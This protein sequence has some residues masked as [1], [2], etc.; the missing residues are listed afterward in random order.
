MNTS[1]TSRTESHKKLLKD[2]LASFAAFKESLQSKLS[3]KLA[4]LQT[5][6][7]ERE[8][9]AGETRRVEIEQADALHAALMAELQATHAKEVADLKEKFINELG[10]RVD[11]EAEKRT[12][13]VSGERGETPLLGATTRNT[14]KQQTAGP[15]APLQTMLPELDIQQDLQLIFPEENTRAF[16]R[17]QHHSSHNNNN[18]TSNIKIH[19]GVFHYRGDKYQRGDIFKLSYHGDDGLESWCRVRLS[20][21]GHGEVSVK[22]LGE[23]N[24]KTPFDL[25]IEKGKVHVPIVQM[26]AGRFRVSRSTKSSGGNKE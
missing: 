19:G 12:T 21:A 1:H 7:K 16:S 9:R 4:K 18:N 24:P 8:W 14:R 23:W 6:S 10:K 5:L 11:G 25:I 22:A 26:R 3:L 15:S 17:R 20:H 13:A 2:T